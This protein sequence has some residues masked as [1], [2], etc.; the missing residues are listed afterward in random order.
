MILRVVVIVGILAFSLLKAVPT[1]AQVENRLAAYTGR[2]AAGYLEP[3]VDAFNTVLNSGLFHSA[4]IHK[5]GV[6]VSL[7]FNYMR[8]YFGGEDRTFTATTEH[9]FQ[10]EQ[11]VEAPTVV[12][13][14]EA[15][16]VEGQGGTRFAFPGGFG[17][18]SFSFAAPQIRVGALYGTEVMFRCLFMNTGTADLGSLNLYGFGLRHDI[19]RHVNIDLPVDI[20]VG[21][22][23]QRFSM[24]EN[25]GGDELLAANTFSLGFH[26]SKKLRRV[27]PYA[28]LSYDRFSMAVSYHADSEDSSDA[29][30]LSFDSEEN[31]HAVLGLSLSLAFVT[32]Q[33]EYN[34]AA[35]NAIS[36]GMS[37]HKHH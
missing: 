20:S 2:N 6:N 25:R 24:G 34:I 14:K 13:A 37:L 29:I 33:G 35:Q 3:L 18:E 28:G 22:F 15:V 1:A 27:E 8:V 32:I 23:W 31:L 30:D 19:S 10:P 11:T 16:Y 5:N 21:F 17:L 4:R 36:I 7:E 9:G 12:G 26:V